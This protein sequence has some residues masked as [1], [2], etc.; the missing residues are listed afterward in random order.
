MSE[1][2]YEIT[3]NSDR[4]ESRG[5][6]L[7]TN[8]AAPKDVALEIVRSSAYAA[9]FGAMGCRGS[10]SDLRLLVPV[11]TVDSLRSFETELATDM[12]AKA[13][14]AALSKLSPGERAL[15]GLE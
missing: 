11:K 12:L 13:K 9:N 14:A 2:L 7:S 8:F 6:T 15:L 5:A 3:Y 1:E 10:E 4:T